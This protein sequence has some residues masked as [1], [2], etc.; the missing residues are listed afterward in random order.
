MIAL[1]KGITPHYRR[2][3][4]VREMMADMLIPLALLL[5]IPVVNHGARPL[6]VVGICMLTCLLCEVVFC[7][8]TGH[9]VM[10]SDLSFA[11]TGA[12]VAMLLPVNVPFRVAVI[13]CA[14]A[15]LVV[16]MPFGGTGRAPFGWGAVRSQGKAAGGFCRD[17][18]HGGRSAVRRGSPYD[19]RNAQ[20]LPPGGPW[21]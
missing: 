14:F 9:D 6:V 18:H 5:V 15:V 3:E 12:I 16:K 7:L 13:A 10:V 21:V 1:K 17:T 11:V 20:E 19:S 2:S 8:F 4:S